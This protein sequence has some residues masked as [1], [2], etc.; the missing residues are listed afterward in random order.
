MKRRPKCSEALAQDENE[1][2][3]LFAKDLQNT[4]G[5][6]EPFPKFYPSSFTLHTLLSP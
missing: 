6:S 2:L 3:T 5:F 4:T 1:L